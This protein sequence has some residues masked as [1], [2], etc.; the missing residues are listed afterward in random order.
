[1]QATNGTVI[2]S[3]AN[4]PNVVGA[5]D[6]TTMDSDGNLWIAHWG[7]GR[8]SQW[9]V[10]GAEPAKML[11]EIEIPGATQITSLVRARTDSVS[12]LNGLVRWTLLCRLVGWLAGVRLR[13]HGRTRVCVV[14]LL[15]CPLTDVWRTKAARPVRDV[16]FYRA[17]RASPLRRRKSPR[18]LR[19]PRDGARSNGTTPAHVWSSHNRWPGGSDMMTDSDRQVATMVV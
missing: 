7:G 15:M 6:G 3:I 14:A 2:A 13:V 8:V 1:M 19:F 9:E 4:D 11:R 12:R 5:F 16:C 17:I 18:W 10:R